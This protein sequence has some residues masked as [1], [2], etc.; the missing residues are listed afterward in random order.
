M[1]AKA[2]L[3]SSSIC[4]LSVIWKVDYSFVL[5]LFLAKISKLSVLTRAKRSHSMSGS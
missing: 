1:D 2:L 5:A 4:S 3:G